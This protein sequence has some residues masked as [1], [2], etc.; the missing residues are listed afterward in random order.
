MIRCVGIGASSIL[1][2]LLEMVSKI[3]NNSCS[4]LLFALQCIAIY[5]DHRHSCFLYLGSVV[6]DEFG[7]I[8]EYQVG[9]MG[10]LQAVVQEALPLLATPSGMVENPDTVDDLYRLCSRLTQGHACQCISVTAFA[11]SCNA[12]PCP[13]CSMN[14]LHQFRNVH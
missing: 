1:P 10:F 11:D 14:V 9:L 13:S 3:N 7:A 6:V 2:S 4:T 12:L 5:R 8:Q